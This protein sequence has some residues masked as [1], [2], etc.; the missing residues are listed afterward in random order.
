MAGFIRVSGKPNVEYFPKKA[1]TAIGNLAL[2]YFDGSGRI[3]P[4][5]ATSGDH[6]GVCLKKIAST[7]DDYASETSIPVDVAGENDI[8]QVGVAAST[9][10]TLSALIGTYIDLT[11]STVADA[12]AS[13]KDAL[14]VV[15]VVDASTI[16]V[17]IAS[18]I[19]ILRTATT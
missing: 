12:T 18:R 7:D 8:F 15:G 17:K 16:L 1:S 3:Q 9:V 14:L 4:A 19:N 11:S 6:L 5:D 10:A 13:S 2:V